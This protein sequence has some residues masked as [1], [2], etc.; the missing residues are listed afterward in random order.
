MPIGRSCC[1]AAGRGRPKPVDAIIKVAQI[2][3]IRIVLSEAGIDRQVP[4]AARYYCFSCGQANPRGALL[5]S[6]FAGI[7]SESKSMTSKA[8][9]VWL[10]Q[11]LFESALIVV[12]ILVA[13]GLDEWRENRQ[14]AE[15]IRHALSSFL[16][17]VEQN[18]NRVE[19]AAPFNQGLRNVLYSHYLEDDID[20]LDDFVSML[21]SYSPAVLQSTAWETALATGS[22]AK[23][24][25]KVVS[26][27]SLTYSLQ[28][29]YQL[30]N[31]T[32]FYELTSPQ[33]LAEGRLKL[34][35]YNSIRYLDNITGMETDLG[36]VYS[37]AAT[38]IQ[39][40]LARMGDEDAVA[41]VK[42]DNAAASR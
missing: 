42:M 8:T 32:G 10:P 30:A 25:Y 15:V 22:L 14:D 19:D 27:L 28:N 1:A 17:E 11:V 34:A 6:G 4:Q 40:E 38:V 21:E 37:E 41:V 9:S 24:D 5:Y 23:M 18:Q 36:V 35:V 31:R 13:L 2:T 20:S 33:N 26:A 16:S 12:S 7:G 39:A 3:D 29:R